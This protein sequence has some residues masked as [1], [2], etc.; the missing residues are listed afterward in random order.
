MHISPIVI[1]SFLTVILSIPFTDKSLKM[2]LYT[3]HNLPAFHPELQ[4]QFTFA[5]VG[6]YF[7]IS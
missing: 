6:Q 5:L 2:D 3:V 7:A 1:D 4:V